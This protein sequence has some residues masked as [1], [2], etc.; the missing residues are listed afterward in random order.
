MSKLGNP[1]MAAAA[2]TTPEGADVAKELIK[3]TRKTATAGIKTIGIVL[4]TPIVIGAGFVI[5]HKISKS[6]EV[7]R[8]QNLWNNN[9]NNPFFKNATL[10][11]QYMLQLKGLHYGDY[12]SI[13]YLIRDKINYKEDWIQV[14]NFYEK[15]YKGKKKS[16][17]DDTGNLMKHLQKIFFDVEKWKKLLSIINSKPSKTGT[18]EYYVKAKNDTRIVQITNTN[19]ILGQQK[20]A[21][22]FT[23]KNL[24]Y[25]GTKTLYGAAKYVLLG[26]DST[27]LSKKYII[28][29]QD[30][31]YLTRSDYEKL[32][33]NRKYVSV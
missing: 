1:Y 23:L 21:K 8:E 19:M 9:T 3:E 6:I 13:T 17:L 29:I 28:P 31:I 10:L 14:E 32:I 11:R 7:N 18:S 33:K 20:V 24:K 22:G 2:L 26:A 25:L 15:L 4:M 30:V 16:P 12:D 5:F 27:Q